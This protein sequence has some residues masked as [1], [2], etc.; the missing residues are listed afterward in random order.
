LWKYNIST[1]N[2]TDS[3]DENV[4][5]TF[6]EEI[7]N[8]DC[9]QTIT[10]TWT[11]TDNCGNATTASQTIN[12][13]DNGLPVIVDIPGDI[14]VDCDNIPVAIDLIATDDCDSDVPVIFNDEITPGACTGTYLITRTWTAT[15]DCGNATSAQQ[16]VYVFDIVAPVFDNIPADVEAGCDEIPEIPNVED[17]TA[18]DDCDSEV[19]IAFE[20]NIVDNACGQTITRTWT[21]TDDCGNETVATQT[22]SIGDD[23]A[24]EIAN[25]PA[26]ITADCDN[27]PG[28]A[29][30]ITATDGCDD[31]VELT[32]NEEILE[33][34]CD[35]NYVIFRTWTATDACG[36][37][38]SETQT[39]NVF[40]IQA[41]VLEG[42]PTNITAACDEIPD[43]P[44]VGVVSVT[45]NC[46]NAVQI[47]F[48]ETIEET[49]CGQ[50]I[51]RKWTAVD[52]CGNETVGEQIITVGDNAAPVIADVPADA[53]V[54]C[55]NI[56]DAAQLTATDDCD[57][58]M[59]VIFSDVITN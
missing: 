2:A 40:D 56:P 16:F 38:T 6:A 8:N 46:D 26:D 9:G 55:D 7:T 30:D 14:S 4:E 27:I 39:I 57:S 41:P 15:D 45:D 19:D 51:T 33:G 20:E 31:E 10:R 34:S 11:A 22:I 36:N 37:I 13:G 42:V 25:I 48:G 59:S 52:E 58:N 54:E 12:V 50:I 1:T 49:D 44:Q 35:G 18:T 29:T 32:T 24:P 17:I 53:T 43:V 47:Q 3:C 23:G 28:I 21:A 5:V